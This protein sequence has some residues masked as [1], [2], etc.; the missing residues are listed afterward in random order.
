MS[1]TTHVVSSNGSWQGVVDTLLCDR[2]CQWFAAGRWFSPATHVSSTN[3]ADHHVITDIVLKVAFNTTT[4]TPDFFNFFELY[5][6]CFV[7]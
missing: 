3:K 2:V 7:H 4:L 5:K 1:I 6:V